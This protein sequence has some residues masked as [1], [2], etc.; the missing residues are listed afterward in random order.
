MMRRPILNRGT[1]SH[2]AEHGVKVRDW[3]QEHHGTDVWHGD[4]C[5]CPDDR[6]AGHHHDDDES[7]GYFASLLREYLSEHK[8]GDRCYA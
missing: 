4:A 6:C 8:P 5:G 3:A 1:R 7:C 2:L